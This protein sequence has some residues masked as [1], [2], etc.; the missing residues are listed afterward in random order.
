MRG[1]RMPALRSMRKTA[2]VMLPGSLEV[3][4]AVLEHLAM[5]VEDVAQHREQVLLDAADHLAVDERRRRR[6]AQLE[7]HAPGL[8]HDAD[9][10]V[11][12]ALEDRAR[13]VGLAAAVQHRERAAAEERVEPAT[14]GIEQPVDLVLRE[15][16]EAAGR[17]DPRIDRVDLL[18]GRHDRF[19]LAHHGRISIGRPTLVRSQ[20]STM[21]ELL[22]AMQPSVQSL[23]A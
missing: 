7:L 16:L 17:R 2:L 14:R 3:D 6:V 13:V 23:C 9:I 11:R 4:R 21:S 12:V 15:V 5:Q 8:A 10:E 1:S 18:E 20:M 19:G 22:T